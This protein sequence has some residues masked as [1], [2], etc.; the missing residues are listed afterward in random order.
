MHTKMENNNVIFLVFHQ[1]AQRCSR[2]EKGVRGGGTRGSPE[3][4]VAAVFPKRPVVVVWCVCNLQF[5][6]CVFVLFGQVVVIVDGRVGG[7][8]AGQTVNTHTHRVGTR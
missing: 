7:F 6:L 8:R 3:A 2:E 5:F 1:D 4:D